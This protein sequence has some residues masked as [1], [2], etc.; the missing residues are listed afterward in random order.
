MQLPCREEVKS[1][2]DMRVMG[3]R[4]QGSSP[5]SPLLSSSSVLGIDEIW[6]VIYYFK[7][8]EKEGKCLGVTGMWPA[9][10]QSLQSLLSS[11]GC[12]FPHMLGGVGRED[13]DS[14]QH[15]DAPLSHVL[16]KG[17]L[18]RLRSMT[19]FMGSYKEWCLC[20]KK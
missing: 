3:F 17:V 19:C 7:R 18:R 15:Q 20:P 10:W 1:G 16:G 11:F 2:A 4:E 6:F 8:R 14:L 13:E 9:F 12:G 5:S